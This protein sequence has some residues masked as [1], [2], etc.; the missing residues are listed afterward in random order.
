MEFGGGF[1]K[2]HAAVDF[3]RGPGWGCFISSSRRFWSRVSGE[4]DAM[5]LIAPLPVRFH[6]G[7]EA[8]LWHHRVPTVKRKCH[9]CW[10]ESE[11][12]ERSRFV[13]CG[14]FAWVSL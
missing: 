1:L 14:L 4:S 5:S 9:G 12:P 6:Q 7:L 8:S 2:Y 11:G 13:R 3:P 10:A